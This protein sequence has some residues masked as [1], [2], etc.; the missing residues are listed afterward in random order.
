LRAVLVLAAVVFFAVL[1]AVVRL[2]T[3]FFAGIVLSAVVFRADVAF[4]AGATPAAVD[5]RA[6]VRFADGALAFDF[7]AAARL[8][9]AAL[10]AEVF[11]AAARGAAGVFVACFAAAMV[12][13]SSWKG[14]RLFAW[15]AGVLRMPLGVRPGHLLGCSLSLG[16]WRRARAV[17]VGYPWSLV[18][19]R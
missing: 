1:A 9:V 7:F 12:S 15:L 10:A 2:D 14:S 17:I 18:S 3:A 11:F 5:L 16:R 13:V 8:A 4:V 6:V 19:A